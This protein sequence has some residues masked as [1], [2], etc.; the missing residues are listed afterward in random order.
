MRYLI[1]CLGLLWPCLSWAAFQEPVA[2]GQLPAATGPVTRPSGSC[3]N[4]VAAAGSG[5]SQ[6]GNP[7][8]PASTSAF[9]M[10]GLAGAI[11]PTRTGTILMIVSGNFISSAVT[12]GDGIKVQLSWG[13]STAPSN[14]GALAGTQC[15]PILEYTNPSTVTA[16][17][18]FVPFTLNCVV[19]GRVLNTALWIDVA[20]E[21][22]A[23]ISIVGLANVSISAIEQ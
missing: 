18:V 22:V 12:A 6:P 17:D 14:A 8:A 9:K 16:A 11:T 4:S 1:L 20:A 13:T 2:C 7:T 21:S 15:G 3:V 5:Q 23:V 19:T 10:Q